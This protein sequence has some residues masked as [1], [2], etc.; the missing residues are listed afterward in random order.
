MEEAEMTLE[1]APGQIED[2]LLETALRL[3]INRVS[4]GVQ[5][6]IDAEAQAVGRSHTERSCI[7]EFERLR[8]AGVTNLGADLIA[9]L[10]LQT[11]AS[12]G[13]VA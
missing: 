4:L 8:A 9:G 3:G 7:A 2:G 13:A 12:L 6:F 10:P 1:A 5:T 11:E